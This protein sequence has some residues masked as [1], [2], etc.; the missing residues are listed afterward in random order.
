MLW[1]TSGKFAYL[2]YKEIE[3]KQSVY[4]VPVQTNG[5]PK[6]P[7]HGITSKDDLMNAHFTVIPHS[8]ESAVSPSLYTYTVQ[9]TRRNLFRVPLQ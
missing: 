6:L 8:V 3:E 4:L 2:K 1:D 7:P 5:L 9:N